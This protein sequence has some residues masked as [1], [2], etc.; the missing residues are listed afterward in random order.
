MSRVGNCWD[1]AVAERFFHPLKTH[2]I[3]DGDDKTREEG[4]KALFK[5]IE[6]YYT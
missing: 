5:Y 6:I 4:N 1:N 3:H 2:I